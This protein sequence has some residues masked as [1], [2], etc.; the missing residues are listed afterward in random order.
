ME[1]IISPQKRGFGGDSTDI[2]EVLKIGTN[3]VT[4]VSLLHSHLSVKK[5]HC[6]ECWFVQ[7]LRA[8]NDIVQHIHPTVSN[9]YTLLTMV[10]GD[11]KWFSVLDSK[12]EFFYI[13]IDEQAQLLF[14]F[15]WQDP[16][17]SHTPILLDCAA[18]I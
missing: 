12:D 1:E 13:P 17:K 7:D 3:P 11:S 14:D 15:K 8:I 5:L 2:A 4:P 18:R 9:P 16:E 10:H 6:D